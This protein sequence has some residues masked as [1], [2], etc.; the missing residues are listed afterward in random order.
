MSVY[1]DH[2]SDPEDEE[3]EYRR[4]DSILGSTTSLSLMSQEFERKMM[5]NYSETQRS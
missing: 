4:T 3:Y 1:D 5:L 2:N